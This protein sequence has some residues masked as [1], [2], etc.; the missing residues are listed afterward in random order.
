M[1]S[2]PPSSSPGTATPAALAV[3]V[4]VDRFRVVTKLRLFH[5]QRLTLG[6]FGALIVIS[7]NLWH[8]P[9]TPW[10][11]P[12]GGTAIGGLFIGLGAVLL[13]IRSETARRAL[14]ASKGPPRERILQAVACI[15]QISNAWLLWAAAGHVLVGVATLLRAR[16]MVPAGSQVLWLALLPTV[17][18]IAYGVCCI[19]TRARLMTLLNEGRG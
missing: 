2:T 8:A 1:Q 17:G 9:V 10:L 7:Y 16:L 14:H 4:L 19:P 11:S 13:W 12:V 5:W 15:G 6:V 18:L 3:T